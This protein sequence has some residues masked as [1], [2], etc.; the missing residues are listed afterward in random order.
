MPVTADDFWSFF[1]LD[2][3]RRFGK[4]NRDRVHLGFVRRVL[5]VIDV[6]PVGFG[7]RSVRGFRDC[8]R[9]IGGRSPVHCGRRETYLVGDQS[10]NRDQENEREPNSSQ[11]RDTPIN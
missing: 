3:R 5:K 7:Q 10:A 1:R 8:G 4:D 2:D 11:H 9:L 6:Q